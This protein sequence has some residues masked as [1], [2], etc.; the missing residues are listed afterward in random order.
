MAAI[1][2]GLLEIAQA[3][4]AGFAVRQNHHV[5][6]AIVGSYLFAYTPAKKKSSLNTIL[7]AI[8]GALP[9][10]AGWAAST[11]TM[12]FEAWVIASIIFLWQLPHFLSLAWVYREDYQ[13]AGF[14][15]LT[16]EE[17]NPARIREK[18]MLYTFALV[19]VSLLPSLI[20]ITGKVYFLG[21][22]I[23]GMIFCWKAFKDLQN[24][25]QGAKPFFLYSVLYLFILQILMVLDK[26]A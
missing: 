8:P 1:E 2:R 24:L 12:P 15:M 10:V 4:F 23:L 22:L 18:L 9:P 6:I 21:A 14:V 20:G 3:H 25:D 7:G 5:T 16:V 17:K 19:P 11:N 13:R 26:R